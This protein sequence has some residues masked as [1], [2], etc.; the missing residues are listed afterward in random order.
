MKLLLPYFILLIILFQFYLR[1][2]SKS[3]SRRDHAFWDREQAA[4]S[5]RRKDI[6][7]LPYISIPDS[8]PFVDTDD[9]EIANAQKQ[10]LELKGKRI[11]N[12]TGKSNTDLKMEYGVANLTILSEYDDNFTLLARAVAAAGC[13]LLKKGY[14]EEGCAFLEFGISC[15]T[16]ITS[17]YTELAAYYAETGHP[18][19]LDT[20]ISAA[21]QLD[22]L[23]KDV[24]LK[25]LEQYSSSVL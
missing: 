5:V 2:N 20:L 25:R 19:K 13:A 14:K 6:N 10:I 1:K 15:R 22:S 4:N 3:S 11:L 21:K 24:I 7:S 8:L 12:L 18:E 16:D 17:N 23:S 9:P